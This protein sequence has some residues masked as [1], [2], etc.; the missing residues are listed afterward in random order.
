MLKTLATVYIYIYILTK[1]T[2]KL[3]KNITYPSR[4]GLFALYLANNRVRDG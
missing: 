2:D 3:I 1:L 4:K